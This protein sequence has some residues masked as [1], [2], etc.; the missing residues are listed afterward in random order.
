LPLV[1]GSEKRRHL[2]SAVAPPPGAGHIAHHLRQSAVSILEHS[3]GSFLPLQR[4]A[5]RSFGKPCNQSGDTDALLETVGDNPR[6]GG[7][8]TKIAPF[9]RNRT[10]AVSESFKIDAKLCFC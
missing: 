9:R 7:T 5:A 2:G 10:F 6:L 3:T 8:F 4:S 1:R